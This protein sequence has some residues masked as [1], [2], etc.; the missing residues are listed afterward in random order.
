MKLIVWKINN[1]KTE[2]KRQ[3]TCVIFAVR[4]LQDAI[5]SASCIENDLSCSIDLSRDCVTSE[6]RTSSKLLSFYA[7]KKE[8]NWK[9]KKIKKTKQYYQKKLEVV[10]LSFENHHYIHCCYL[11]KICAAWWVVNVALRACQVF[12]FVSHAQL[13]IHLT[14]SK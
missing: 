11:K 2:K 14:Q 6:I 4:R 10:Q 5:C 1:E 13:S 7:R 8:E 9:M 3:H 12:G